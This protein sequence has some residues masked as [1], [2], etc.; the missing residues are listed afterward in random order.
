M[1]LKIRQQS[2]LKLYH[3]RVTAG[4]KEY[5]EYWIDIGLGRTPNRVSAEWG[6]LVMCR[7]IPVAW[8]N[9]LSETVRNSLGIGDIWIGDISYSIDRGE[10][11]TLAVSCGYTP[12]RGRWP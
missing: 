11:G 8:N 2:Y 4:D 10:G 6:D 7:R 12:L 5:S 9:R 3:S 1:E